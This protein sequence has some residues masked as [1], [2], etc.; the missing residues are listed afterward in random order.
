[1]TSES[2]HQR[3][4]IETA[5]EQEHSFVGQRLR[6]RSEWFVVVLELVIH[7]MTRELCL[8][9]NQSRRWHALRCCHARVAFWQ[10]P[11]WVHVLL[12]PG[13]LS[14]HNGLSQPAAASRG[15]AVSLLGASSRRFAMF[16]G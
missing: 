8:R 6:D 1:M 13:R 4:W 10:Q 16:F 15:W 3:L 12:Q 14:V 7:P 2:K 11:S 9:D 5:N